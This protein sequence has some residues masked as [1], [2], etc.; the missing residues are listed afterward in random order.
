M[1]GSEILQFVDYIWMMC[2]HERT[3][4]KERSS[5]ILNILGYYFHYTDFA[6]EIVNAKI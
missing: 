3:G 6:R 4:K 1:S 5:G 2:N